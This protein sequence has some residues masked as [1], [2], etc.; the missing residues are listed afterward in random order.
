MQPSH[1]RR[2]RLI[3]P[4]QGAE[5]QAAHDVGHSCAKHADTLATRSRNEVRSL[6]RPR[7]RIRDGAWERVVSSAR[8]E[9]VRAARARVDHEG[10]GD[11][12][13]QRVGS[14]HV[15]RARRRR[16]GRSCLRRLPGRRSSSRSAGA[17][18][19]VVGRRDLMTVLEV[20]VRRGAGQIAAGVRTDQQRL[21]QWCFVFYQHV[22]E[23]PDG[24]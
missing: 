10:V 16:L 13:L 22:G 9:L 1:I 2:G 20:D 24:R 17:R 19:R 18:G 21:L 4:L 15:A 11:A 5:E 23:I 14:R 12:Q 6:M 3:D 7:E 8:R